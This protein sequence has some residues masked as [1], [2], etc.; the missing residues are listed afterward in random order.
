MKSFKN[1]IKETHHSG[2]LLCEVHPGMA[3]AVPHPALSDYPHGEAVE[4]EHYGEFKHA[5]AEDGH[6]CV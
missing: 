2:G 6:S 3:A 1:Y 5:A 4:Q